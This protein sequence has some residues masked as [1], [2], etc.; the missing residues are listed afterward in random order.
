[1][2]EKL[3]ARKYAIPLIFAI[4]I[5]CIMGI[6]FYPMMNMQVKGIPFAVLSLDEGVETSQGQ[7][8]MGDALAENM[9]SSAA[10]AE[11]EGEDPAIV[12]TVLESQE[13]LD[14]ALA[15][16]EFYGA[17][18]I[19]SDFSAAQYQSL[20]DT[21]GEQMGNMQSM[22]SSAM[23]AMAAS[24]AAPQ[25]SSAGAAALTP[26]TTSAASGA[27]DG[28]ISAAQGVSSA[29]QGT[30]AQPSTGVSG[31]A[32]AKMVE[33]V[34]AGN[35]VSAVENMGAAAGEEA[36]ETADSSPAITLY[37]DVAKNPMMANLMQ[38]NMS[39]MFAST[40]FALDVVKVHDMPAVEGESEEGAEAAVSNPM[41]SMMAQN[42]LIMPLVMASIVIGILMARI[43]AKEEGDSRAQ[44]GKKIGLQLS[45]ALVVSGVLAGLAFLLAKELGGLNPPAADTVLFMWVASFC[46]MACVIG[47][48]NIVF[49]LAV[50]F[51][52][53]AIP[54]GMSLGIL[55]PE[56]LPAFWREWVYPWV[57]QRFLGEGLRQVMYMGAGLDNPATLAFAAYGAA[58]AVLAAAAI[59]VPALRPKRSRSA[60]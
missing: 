47:L 56:V 31:E 18:V 22:M 42:V 10:A 45:Y 20:V 16:N 28:T 43:F 13:K 19:P 39:S 26:E 30:I 59:F 38:S 52:V 57:P 46:L 27:Q 48:G 1:M 11:G 36:E 2:F 24:A 25:A 15:E 60:E 34:V 23:A 29:A 3:G 51:A 32:L 54:L 35:L 8:N 33:G 5:L 12:W 4:V 17:I 37:I 9:T 53:C 58:G 7:V 49:G 50:L 44:A 14:A 40:G 41:A 55:P 6:M 21:M